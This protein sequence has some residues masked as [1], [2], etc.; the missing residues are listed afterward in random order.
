MPPNHSPE[1][2]PTAFAVPHS[3]LTLLAARLSFWR[4]TNNQIMKILVILLATLV[5]LPATHAASQAD[6][7]HAEGL[8]GVEANVPAALTNSALSE[9]SQAG[10]FL[11]ELRK[12]GHLPGVPQDCHGH[13][14]VDAP[15]SAILEAKYPF[16][17]TIDLV[18]DGDSLT[19]HYTVGR[20]AKDASW[21]LDKAWRTDTQGHTV[22]EWP[23]K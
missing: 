12:S 5:L 15:L 10:E 8:A 4:S 18:L 2:T 7:S 22:V 13:M 23:V 3:R 6:A 17:V 19:N 1:T 20:P 16:T 9:I 11:G 14:D 21:H